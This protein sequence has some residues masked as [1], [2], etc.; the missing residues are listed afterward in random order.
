MQANNAAINTVRT[1]SLGVTLIRTELWS[2][3]RGWADE[4][5]RFCLRR[6]MRLHELV[7]LTCM[8]LY[9]SVVAAWVGWC[10]VVP[11]LACMVA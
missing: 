4:A 6:W 7:N 1:P 8:Y 5:G 2:D 9:F 10:T 11:A 3:L